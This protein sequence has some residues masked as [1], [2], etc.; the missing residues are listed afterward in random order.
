MAVED[1]YVNTYLESGDRA[2]AKGEIV[3]ILETFEVAAADDDGSV[4]RVFSIPSN[5]IPLA[6]GKVYHDNITGGTDYEFGLYDAKSGAAVDIDVFLGTTSM[7]NTTTLDPFSLAMDVDGATTAIWSHAGGSADTHK[8]YDW[9][10]TANTVG[11][12]AGTI[13]VFA[14]YLIKG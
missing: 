2:E 6:G 12:A 7:A 14:Q 11:T 13:T 4:Y 9:A 10:I 8:V 1:K 3:T 5:A